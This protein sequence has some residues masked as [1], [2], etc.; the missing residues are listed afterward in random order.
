MDDANPPK[1]HPKMPGE[2]H[3]LSISHGWTIFFPRNCWLTYV[4]IHHSGPKPTSNTIKR[5]LSR[6]LIVVALRLFTGHLSDIVWRHWRRLVML[7]E[8]L[9]IWI[10]HGDLSYFIIT[11]LNSLNLDQVMLEMLEM[12]W[13]KGEHLRMSSYV[14]GICGDD[15]WTNSHH[16]VTENDVR[17]QLTYP[18]VNQHSELENCHRNSWFT[19]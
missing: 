15:H 9:W 17:S 4:N 19:H 7:K 5:N 8:R 18:L 14:V 10:F 3:S 11:K 6:D 1:N 13:K 16:S 2:S 12:L